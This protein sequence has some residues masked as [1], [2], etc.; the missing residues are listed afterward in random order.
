MKHEVGA[1][2][3]LMPVANAILD[4]WGFDF[5]KAQG[6]PNHRATV[7]HAGNLSTISHA[8]Y[9]DTKQKWGHKSLAYHRVDLHQSLY[10]LVTSQRHDSKPVKIKSEAEVAS[11]DCEEGRLV[12]KSGENFT[13]DLLVIADGAHVGLLSR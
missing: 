5:G 8:E 3:T 11:I 1:A 10:E 2:I 9:R 6:V 13:K 7:L 12:L 4:D